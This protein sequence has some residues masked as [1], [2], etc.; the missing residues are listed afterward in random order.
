MDEFIEYAYTES[1]SNSKDCSSVDM[2]AHTP[3]AVRRRRRKEKEP[4]PLLPTS[5]GQL[6]QVQHLSQ[7]HPP[8]SKNVLVKPV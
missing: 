1:H 7:R 3:R 2:R 6:L 4:P 8:Q 5:L